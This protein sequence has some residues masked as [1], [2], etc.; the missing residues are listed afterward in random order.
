MRY[1]ELRYSVPSR[2]DKN[3]DATDAESKVYMGRTL[4]VGFAMC[5]IFAVVGCAMTQEELANE[6]PNAQYIV[7]AD[8]RCLYEKGAEK[9]ASSLGMTEPKM[10]GFINSGGGYAWFRQPLT[11]IR[12][13]SVGERST[14]VTRQQHGSAAALRQGSDMLTYLKGNPCAD[15]AK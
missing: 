1:I 2:D 11:L 8:F 15:S 6:Q 12:L 5:V 3:V 10:T 7:A 14:L 9:A 4:K 13:Q